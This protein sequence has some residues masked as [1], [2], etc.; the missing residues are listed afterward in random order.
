[1]QTLSAPIQTGSNLSREIVWDGLD[2]YG[3]RLAR[4][5]YLYRLEVRNPLTGETAHAQEKL[6][7]LR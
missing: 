6:V 5:V 1:M 4:G 7:L 2:S 3:D